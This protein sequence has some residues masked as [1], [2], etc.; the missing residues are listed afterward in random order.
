MSVC[1][2]K[3]LEYFSMCSSFY[4]FFLCQILENLGIT[5]INTILIPIARLSKPKLSLISKLL[6]HIYVKKHSNWAFSVF[7]D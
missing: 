4:F 2:P 7:E 5:V 6:F 1:L 3:I